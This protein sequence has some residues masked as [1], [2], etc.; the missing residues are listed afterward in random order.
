MCVYIHSLVGVQTMH[1]IIE[2]CTLILL[3]NVAQK[4]FH[5]CVDIIFSAVPL[6]R[7][8]CLTYN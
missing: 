5:L 8:G 4:L 7:T 3:N 1:I 2:F 6:G